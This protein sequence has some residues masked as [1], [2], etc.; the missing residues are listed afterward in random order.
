[1]NIY[2]KNGFVNLFFDFLSKKPLPI[3]YLDFL[4][5]SNYYIISKSR[6]A[7][8]AEDIWAEISG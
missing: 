6:K 7:Q 8:E 4:W 3:I 1:L 2:W 5:S